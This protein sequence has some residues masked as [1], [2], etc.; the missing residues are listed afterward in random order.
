M[1]L[2]SIVVG[3]DISKP[4]LDCFVHPA[5]QHCRF[6][7]TASGI[8][9]VVALAQRHG[10]FCILEATGPCDG[11]L[12]AAL[13]A[14]GIS[15][16]LANPRK[17]RYFAR[18]GGFLAKT[19]RVD[20]RMLAA[21]GA[22][23]ALPAERRSTPQREELRALITRRDQ[24]VEMRKMERTRLSDPNPEWLAHSLAQIIAVLD[25]HIGALEQSIRI[26]VQSTPALA[27]QHHILCSAPGVG[28]L[29]ASVLMALLPE[30]GQRHRRA[31]SALAGLA[32]IAFE[33]GAMRGTR[34]IWGGRKRVRDALYMAALSACRVNPTFKA[35]YQAL[36]DRGKP[37]KLAL[38]AIARRLLVALNAAIRDQKPFHA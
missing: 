13:H 2:P 9:G 20:A 28:Q 12:R 6:A 16:H 32:P 37:P 30:L 26:L 21:Y 34:H 33:S 5:G 1:S 35:I 29:T 15:F 25:G 38:I 36:R 17:A 14:A 4:W 3:I 11:A 22:C 27:A 24:L 10:A 19:D 18:S 8:E 23:V 31:I 7:N